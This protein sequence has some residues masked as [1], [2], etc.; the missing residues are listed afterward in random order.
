MG[1]QKGM[2]GGKDMPMKGGMMDGMPMCA[3]MMGEGMNMSAQIDQ[4]LGA[5]R[6]E[7]NITPAQVPSWDAYASALRGTAANMDSMRASM[8]AGHQGNAPISPIE[9]RW[10]PVEQSRNERRRARLGQDRAA[11]YHLMRLRVR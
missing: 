2:M 9:R 11:V 6:S 10:A 8:M 3:M 5:L 7:L 4:R 1:G